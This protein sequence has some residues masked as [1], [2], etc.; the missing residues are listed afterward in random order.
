MGLEQQS[1]FDFSIYP[2]PSSDFLNIVS[3]QQLASVEVY[4]SL[5]QLILTN[6]ISRDTD[7]PKIEVKGLTVGLYFI[8]M[9]TVNGEIGLLRFLKE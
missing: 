5:G 8:K 6:Q 4:N 2:N 9:R 1:F 3:Q 7:N